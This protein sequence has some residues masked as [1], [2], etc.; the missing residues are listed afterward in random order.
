VCA[1]CGIAAHIPTVVDALPTAPVGAAAGSRDGVAVGN[2][3]GPAT[4]FAA[5]RNPDCRVY[6][7]GAMLSMMADNVEH[8]ITYWVLFQTFHSPALAGFAVISHWAPSLLLS[9]YF[10]VAG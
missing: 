5:L 7:A 8:V 10:R 9:V 6:L 1:A 3:G 4:K 2:G